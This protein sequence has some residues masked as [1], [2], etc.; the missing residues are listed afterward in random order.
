M[1]VHDEL[2]GIYSLL[3]QRVRTQ[4]E[5]IDT[6]IKRVDILQEM[7]IEMKNSNVQERIE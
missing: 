4:S 7:V 6:L 5:C 2:M 1:S 3:L